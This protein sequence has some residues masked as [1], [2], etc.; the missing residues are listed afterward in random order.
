MVAKLLLKLILFHRETIKCGDSIRL[1]H[2]A[3]K[4]NLHS[5]HFQ[6]PLSGNQEISCYGEDGIGDSGDTWEVICS[7]EAWQRDYPVK[8]RHIDTAAYLSVSGRTFGR[9]INGQMEVIGSSDPQHAA[10]WQAA[11]GLFIHP[12]DLKEHAAAHTEL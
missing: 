6:S 7:G 1:Q 10:D 4:R 9:P 3:T 2:V 5:H 8:L 11:E 12:R